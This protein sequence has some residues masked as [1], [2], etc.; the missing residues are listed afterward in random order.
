M[1]GKRDALSHACWL[2]LRAAR[3]FPWRWRRIGDGLGG[4]GWGSLTRPAAPLAASATLTQAHSSYCV[5]PRDC[6]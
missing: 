2:R 4:R 1:A 5:R 3:P 6:E